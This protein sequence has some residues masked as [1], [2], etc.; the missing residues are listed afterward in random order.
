M[1]HPLE[2]SSQRTNY[3]NYQIIALGR[4]LPAFDPTL[5]VKSVLLSPSCVKK[6]NSLVSKYSHLIQQT[7]VAAIALRLATFAVPASM[8]RVLAPMSTV[9]HIPGLTVFAAGMRTEYIA[10]VAR[11]FDLWFVQLAN[12]IWAITLSAVL[13]DLRILLVATCWVVYTISLFQ[14]TNLRTTSFMVL[15]SAWELVFCVLLMLWL[16]LGLVDGVQ[17]HALIIARGHT[18]STKDVLANAL[19]TMATMALRNMFRRHRHVQLQRTAPEKRMQALGYRCKIALSIM[20][21]HAESQGSVILYKGSNTKNGTPFF[22]LIKAK[23]HP[24]RAERRTLLQMY[25]VAE[26]AKIDP[27]KTVWPRIGALGPIAIWKS[28]VLYFC[29]VM[30]AGLAALSVFLPEGACGAA[31]IAVSA[32]IASLFFSGV[33]L[34]CCQIQLLKSIMTSFHFLFLQ[35]QIVTIGVCVV[36]M[37]SWRWHCACGVMCSCVLAFTVLTVDALTPVMKQRLRFNYWMVVG[38]ILLFWLVQ[39]VLLLDVLVLGQL[40]LKDRV[41]LNFVVLGTQ[42]QFRVAPFPVLSQF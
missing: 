2:L 36:D 15:V 40:D 17:N 19:G 16:S 10:I 25:L 24:S 20:G 39:M 33:H 3:G 5:T 21:P 22:T 32:L 42:S 12:T 28:V 37:L 9:F 11:T 38:G 31:E 27:H 41:F 18:L 26:H 29:G 6:Y 35:F 30:G 23:S 8:G 7:V 4:H 1:I 34:C 14:E 13:M